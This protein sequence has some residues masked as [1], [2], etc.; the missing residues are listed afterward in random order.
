M[1]KRY[2]TS[3]LTVIKGVNHYDQSRKQ[4]G[5]PYPS[6]NARIFRG[7]ASGVF[8]ADSGERISNLWGASSKPLGEM[9]A[10]INCPPTIS[11]RQGEGTM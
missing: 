9:I 8:G 6:V 2:I 11:Q 4:E 3:R 5:G 7:V 1:V 10:A